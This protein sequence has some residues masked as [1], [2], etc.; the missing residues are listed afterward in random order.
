MRGSVRLI[1]TRA[2]AL[3]VVLA[4]FAGT[5][6][7]LPAPEL[8]GDVGSTLAVL[9]SPDEGGFSV[10]LAALWP[11]R[12][13]LRFGVTGFAD[14]LGANI[15]RLRDPND[16]TDL[17]AVETAH[18]WVYGGGWRV[19]AG[20]PDR[21]GWV[22]YASGTWGAYRLED[23]HR[24][25]VSRA[26]SSI[27]FSLGGGVVRP[28]SGRAALGVGVRYH[29]LFNDVAG[30]YVSVAAQWRWGASGSE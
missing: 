25:E 1:S 16:G 22:P 17:G 21:W 30:R 11:M 26:L 23:D 15:G 13:G 3:A 2:A 12:A 8:I 18:R 29:R 7:A 5:S 4:V 27:G 28:V 20:L 9:G 14:D 10:A 6:F 19:D 24:G